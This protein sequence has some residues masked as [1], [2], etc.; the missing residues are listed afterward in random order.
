MTLVRKITAA[1]FTA[2]LIILCS[3][4]VSAIPP[5]SFDIVPKLWA[6]SVSNTSIS[7]KW[8]PRP[9]ASMYKVYRSCQGT[10]D[11]KQI[12]STYGTTFIDRGLSPSNS[13]G[14]FVRAYTKYGQAVDSI[15]V[16][17]VTQESKTVLGFTTKYYPGDN[18]SY[19][20]L[21]RN[22][23]MIDEIAT[24][25]Y[26]TD[27]FGN[28]TGTA[29]SSELLYASKQG[30]NAYALVTNNFSGSTAK[31][32]LESP[33]NRG[34]LINNI[35]SALKNNDYKGVNIDFEGIYYYDRGY[36]TTF[37]RE[38][39]N[40][41]HPLEY[42]TTVDVPAKTWDN[43]NNGWSGAYDYHQIQSCADKV[44]IMSYDEHY[45][46]GDPGPIASIG[47]VRDV[48]NYSV[49]Q[50]PGEKILLGTAAYGYDWSSRGTTACT[51]DGI[52]N[53]ASYYGKDILWDSVSMTPYF[54]YT[55]TGGIRHAVWF[56][57]SVSLS[58]KLDIVNDLNLSGI[59]IWKLGLENSSY[60]N[61]IKTK[62]SK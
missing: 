2:V 53:L 18:S 61:T 29:P 48:A 62:L 1:F 15:K 24:Y 57:N 19:N 37:M 13:Y 4:S 14:Y 40:T 45:S 59:A 55:D 7:L 26:T 28:L 51:I 49:T 35:L 42:K 34:R 32:L 31:A 21:L 46:G 39:Y 50:I 12:A 25:T 56:E 54:N 43:P 11:Y 52:N 58:Y 9:G 5:A 16:S 22:S 6:V 36:F 41:L 44:I 20:S 8:T 60:W 10:A 33:T 47:W 30:I 38:L 27:D 3:T 23:S 17:A